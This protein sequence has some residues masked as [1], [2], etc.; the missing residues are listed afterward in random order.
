MRH[1]RDPEILLD[2]PPNFTIE[3]L[4]NGRDRIPDYS[5]LATCRLGFPLGR[6][7]AVGRT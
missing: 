4:A 2:P 1:G 7:A 6:T 5:L 3:I